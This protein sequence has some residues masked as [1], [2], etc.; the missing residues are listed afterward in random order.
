MWVLMNKGDDEA[1]YKK[2]MCGKE[3]QRDSIIPWL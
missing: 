1:S 2:A 3:G